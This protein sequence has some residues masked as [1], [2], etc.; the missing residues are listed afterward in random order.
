M[1]RPRKRLCASV[2]RRMV[3]RTTRGIRCQC[4]W[5]CTRRWTL[6]TILGAL[7]PQPVG[8]SSCSAIPILT[9]SY[10]KQR[11]TSTPQGSS[12]VYYHIRKLDFLTPFP[13]R[14]PHLLGWEM[15]S[16]KPVKLHTPH[17]TS[18]AP[19]LSPIHHTAPPLILVPAM[20]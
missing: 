6:S 1:R 14:K 16:T 12:S 15:A 3:S 17:P 7:Q 11:N 13:L 4:L 8:S 10:S 9:M 5:S 20:L 18:S 2:A 19:L